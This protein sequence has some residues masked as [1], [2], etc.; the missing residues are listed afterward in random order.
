[1]PTILVVDDHPANRELLACILGPSGHDVLLASDGEEG[2]RAANQDRPD[3]IIAD[4]LMPTMDGYEFVRRLR[5]DPAVASVPVIFYT[6]YYLETEALG[7]AAECGVHEIIRK[8]AEP[9]DVLAA[10]NRVLAGAQP[11]PA[12]VKLEDFDH[13]HVRLLTNKLAGNVSE[14]RTANQRLKA[15]VDLGPQLAGGGRE[16]LAET[17]SRAA[18]EIMD[19]SCAGV[20][21]LSDDAN[22]IV[23]VACSGTECPISEQCKKSMAIQGVL[24]AVVQ[25]GARRMIHSG[26]P[27]QLGLPGVLTP[28]HS[29]LGV[30]VGP[31]GRIHGI[32][33]LLNKIGRSEFDEFDQELAGLLA[34]QLTVACENDRLLL[35]S[36]RRSEALERQLER[37]RRMETA[38]REHEQQLSGY[39]RSSPAGMFVLD[40]DYRFLRVNGQL[41]RMN[42]RPRDEHI[43]KTVRSLLPELAPVLEP[44]FEQVL[45]T[46]KPVIDLEVSG[47]TPSQ[48]GIKRSWLASYFSFDRGDARMAIGGV[49]VEITERQRAE[50]ELRV[51][52]EN[53]E[54]RVVERTAKWEASNQELEAFAYSVS[55]DLRAPLRAIDGF[56]R[57]LIE[58]HR[59]H[60]TPDAQHYLDIVAKNAVQMGDLIDHLLVFSRLNR[61]AMN[62]ETL[63]LTAL[64]RQVLA[65]LSAERSGREI[66]IVVRE[67]PPDKAD[68]TL[69]RQVFMNLLS[70]ALKYTRGRE[71]AHIEVGA[72]ADLDGAPVYYVRDNGAGFDMRYSDKLF[73]VFQRLHRAEDYEGTGVG[74]A[75]VQRIIS[76][77]GGRV[78]AEAEIGRG[79]TFYFTLGAADESGDQP[80]DGGGNPKI[81]QSLSTNA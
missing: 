64:V 56:S 81:A 72:S 5:S 73:G 11:L 9:S 65:D 10:V 77:H 67:L 39:F 2:L 37:V 47:E 24:Q 71:R 20:V 70:N 22:R 7:L 50:E 31:P 23:H 54:K 18:R 43:G 34:A 16:A 14:L 8:P 41:A 74:L 45:A 40:S 38:L 62:P 55:H 15:L 28:I 59:P 35:E 79:A 30:R 49:V 13:E 80:P 78:W 3:L 63:D 44:I 29:F 48:P 75:I 4:V 32:L 46:G 66:E 68:A 26:D 36:R 51:L 1:M 69:L 25:E 58:E 12:P 53:L 52:N 57:I 60:L 33:F 76:R 27:G 42:G 19:S 21:L 17:F 61:Q 6:A